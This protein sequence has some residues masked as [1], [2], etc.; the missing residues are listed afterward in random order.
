M[1]ASTTII[2]SPTTEDVIKQIKQAPPEIQK[3]AWCESRWKQFD[4]KGNLIRGKAGE[5]GLLQYLPS[6]WS[7]WNWSRKLEGLTQLNIGVAS[8]QIEMAK[9]AW[10]NGINYKSQWTCYRHLFM[11]EK[12]SYSGDR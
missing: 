1:F 11:D 2:A 5:V 3:V 9:W 7:A 8:H 4:D 12:L 6:T 10:A